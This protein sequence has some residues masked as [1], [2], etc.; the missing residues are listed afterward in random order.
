MGDF[1]DHLLSACL[2]E[3]FGKI[4]VSEKHLKYIINEENIIPVMSEYSYHVWLN[5]FETLHAYSSKN[6]KRSWLLNK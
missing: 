1:P 3:W 5:A 4:V 6:A 2:P